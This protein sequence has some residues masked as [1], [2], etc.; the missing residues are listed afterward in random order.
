MEWKDNGIII[1]RKMFGESHVILELLTENQG[2][3]K[4]LVHGAKSKQ[5]QHVLELGN[6]L[7]VTWK[8]RTQEQ[9]GYFSPVESV[10]ERANRN[11]ESPTALS[12]IQSV[13]ALL[14]TSLDEGDGNES[15]IY[16]VTQI[17][18]N[19]L[20]DFDIWPALYVKWEVFLLSSLG[21]GL[22]L[23]QCALSGATDGLTHVSPRTGK[24]VRYLE[25][26]RY[27]DKLLRIPEFLLRSDAEVENKDLKNGLK[28][29]GYFIKNRMYAAIH[30][31]P[32]EARD[33]LVNK[34]ID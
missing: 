9:L 14:R 7:S 31:A 24:A 10:S 32:P 28:L 4:G 13:T 20:E 6:T 11:L 21:F 29:T 1:G 12:A 22:D 25:A 26:Q 17:L 27:V 18:L 34:L 16:E 30:K 33:I 3:R 2:K 5:R 15:N 19:S 8:G 23:T